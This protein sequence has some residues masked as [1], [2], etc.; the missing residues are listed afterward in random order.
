MVP[1]RSLSNV[2]AAGESILGNTPSLEDANV[3]TNVSINYN[4]KYEF[5]EGVSAERQVKK[6][7]RYK[8]KD[9]LSRR[10]FTFGEKKV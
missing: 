3:S 6:K 4:D 1:W 10:S 7:S 9:K 8:K 2:P 5:S